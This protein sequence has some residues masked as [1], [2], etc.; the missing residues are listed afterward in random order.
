MQL[1][2]ELPRRLSDCAVRD[3]AAQHGI[4]VAAVSA[5]YAK[6]ARANGLVFGFGGVRPAA[7]RAGVKQLAA[8][9]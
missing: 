3:R 5:Y 9:L 4:E 1:W 6:R 8:L 2:A 7:L